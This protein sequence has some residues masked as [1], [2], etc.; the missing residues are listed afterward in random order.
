[1]HG[2]PQHFGRYRLLSQIGAGGLGEVFMAETPDEHI[3]DP[4]VVKRLIEAMA[5]H[6]EVI[7]QFEREAAIGKDV[8]HQH[9]VRIYDSGTV[10]GRHY[11]AMEYCAGGPLVDRLEATPPSPEQSLAIVAAVCD[12]LH[13]L[14]EAGFVHCDVC[15]AN[16]LLGESATDVKLSDYGVATDLGTKQSQMRGTHAYMSPEQVKGHEICQ[17]TDVFAAGVVAWELL[18]RQRLFYRGPSFL[19]FAAVVEDEVPTLDDPAIDTVVRRALSK[20][21]KQ[22]YASVAELA[23]ALRSLL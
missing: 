10:D 22:R 14:H 1:M 21:R 5:R 9:L 18:A 11:M 23:A 13:A 8:A 16:I 15:P 7:A 20:D 6:D 12:G 4:I 3:P 19:T 17:R 2:F